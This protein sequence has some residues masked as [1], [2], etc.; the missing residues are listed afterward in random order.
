M[1]STDTA[2]DGVY[3]KQLLGVLNSFGKGDPARASSAP[4]RTA[5]TEGE[6]GGTGRRSIPAPL[7]L[8]LYPCRTRRGAHRMTTPLHDFLETAPDTM[9][10]VDPDGRIVQVNTQALKLFGY[11]AVVALAPS[12]TL[13]A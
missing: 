8:Q 12:A 2:L 4:W 13:T 5:G 3:A 1:P 7:S 9:L 6:L 11:A 10:L